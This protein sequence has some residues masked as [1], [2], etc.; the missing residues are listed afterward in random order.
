MKKLVIILVVLLS[1][2]VNS[3]SFGIKGGVNYSNLTNEETIK[4]LTNAVKS[5]DARVSY[6]LGVFAEIPIN[7][8]FSLQPELLYS[9]QGVELDG[10]V[11]DGSLHLDYLTI[12]I[13][14]KLYIF[15]PLYFELGIQ[16]SYLFNNEFVIGKTKLFKDTDIFE[17][18]DY[19]ANFGVG[20]KFGKLSANCRYNYGMNGI[21]DLGDSKIS[22]KMEEDAP[23]N[24]VLT[25]SIGYELF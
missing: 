11:K 13:M 3:Q 22:K 18:M 7:D 5:K 14:A 21:L 2:N 17:K 12:P 20:V 4:S 19:S 23:K 15:K 1:Y 25:V 24:S 10:L 6:H 16:G 9:S 8:N